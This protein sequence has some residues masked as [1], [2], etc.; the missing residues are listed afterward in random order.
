MRAFPKGFLWG[1]ATAAN[2]CEGGYQEGGRGLANV[3]FIPSGEQRFAVA[4]GQLDVK[5]LSN[6]EH[7]PGRYAID[8]YHHYKE[9]IALFAE[10]GFQVYRFSIS[11]SR[12]YPQGDEDK[13]N[14]A[15]LRFY[16]E[17][18]D[19][20]LSYGIEPLVTINH[21]DVPLHLIEAYG[22]WRN[23]K[24]VTFY[25]RLCETLFTRFKGKVHYWLTFNEINMILHL[26]Y[27]AAGLTFKADENKTQVCY[28]AAHHELLASAKAVSLAHHID[29]NNQIGCMLA[30][31]NIYPYSCRPEDVM[32]GLQKDR[33]NYYFTDVQ[34]RGYY[35]SYAK[36]F[37]EREHIQLQMEED[38]E[39]ILK[40][41]CIDFVS[42]SYYN[43]GV[44]SADPKLKA[45]AKGN[46]FPS[47][48]NPY[49]PSSEWGWQIDPLGLR[50]TLNTLYDR[51]QKPL[52]I[53]EN[54]LGAKDNFVNGYVE[55]DARIA[56]LREH[57]KAMKDAI[58]LDGVDLLGYTT[59]GCIDL[60]SAS[61][62]EMRK[63]YGFIYVDADEDGKGTLNRYKKKSFY[64]Y[65]K[66]IK[67]NGEDL[68]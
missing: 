19:T 57:I 32:E 41:G 26:P 30:A 35:P 39:A 7:F 51:Y 43:S 48:E 31:G 61:T 68:D 63:R 33:E 52:F 44:A 54:G 6:Q 53:V 25:L 56:Y 4:S 36:K 18:I 42:F 23:R 40:A 29:P 66:V 65:Q 55:D 10:M 62:G 45:A 60:I 59:W 58:L 11:W 1:G 17:V 49:L 5:Q 14:E 2:Q 8:M 37:F 20:C 3:D 16:E 47:I 46:V 50:I 22:A 15:G 12:I 67:S 9:D 21:F 27:M 34:A 64:W 28:Q 24:M 13:P 38:D